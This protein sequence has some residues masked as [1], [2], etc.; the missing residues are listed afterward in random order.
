MDNPT[1]PNTPPIQS[2]P[3]VPI[4]S[5]STNWGKILIFVFLG[6]V[7]VAG[8]VF[9]GIQIGNK[10]TANQRP[11]TEQTTVFP[12]QVVINPTIV[13]T[14]KAISPTINEQT[15][16]YKN[17]SFTYPNSWKFLSKDID[18]NF[19]LKDRLIFDEKIIAIEKDGIYLIVNISK[20]GQLEAGGIFITDKDYNDF[21]NEKN[22]VAID[23]KTF[24]LAKNHPSLSVLKDAHSGPAVWGALSEY[25]PSKSTGSGNIFRG[26]EQIIKKNGYMYNIIVVGQQEEKT[27]TEIQTSIIQIL[28]SIKW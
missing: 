17:F 25:I 8:S 27:P 3:Q 11:I 19:P 18:N 12:T 24:Y 5:P 1:Q 22:E 6:L 16:T 14:T 26:Y 10:Q 23:E 4:S 13:T 9:V 7:V 2:A 15:F 28:E 20:E 21:I